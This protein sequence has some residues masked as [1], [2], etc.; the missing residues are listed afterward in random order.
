MGWLCRKYGMSCDNLIGAQVV[1]ADGKIVRANEKENADLLWALRGGSKNFGIVTEFEVKLHRLDSPEGH[2][3]FAGPVVYKLQDAKRVLMKYKEVMDKAPREMSAY[4]IFRQA[5]PFPFLSE[6]LHFKPVMIVALCYIGSEDTT[7]KN[8]M[9]F[10]ELGTPLG[11]HVGRMPVANW[12]QAFD[13]MMGPGARGYWKSCNYSV[14]SSELFDI[15]VEATPILPNFGSDFLLAPMGGAVG[16]VSVDATA[17]PHRTNKGLVNCHMRW[18]DKAD[19]DKYIGWARDLFAKMKPYVDDSAYLNFIS[20]DE[21]MAEVNVFDKNNARL[22]EIK[23][24]YDPHNFFSETYKIR[25][26]A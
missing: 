23:A 14:L 3:V 17:Y 5:P 22:A 13:A 19:D 18:E 20:A 24:K 2:T 12:N 11:S 26:T 9:P 7:D 8:V 15:M 21:E 16:D 10:M 4:C 6:D 1:T 25:P